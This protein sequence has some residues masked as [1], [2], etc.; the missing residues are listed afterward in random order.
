MRNLYKIVAIG[1][2]FLMASCAK[3]KGNYEFIPKEEITV[4]GIEASY[5][6]TA[7]SDPLVLKPEITSTDPNAKFEYMWGIYETAVQGYAPVLDT[8]AWT[9]D[10]DYEIVQSA[11]A[12]V[13]V[14]RV[15]NTNTGY[16]TYINSTLNVGTLYTRGW[17]VAKD[18]GSQSDLDLF[19]TPESIIPNGDKMENIYSQ[20]NGKKLDGKAKF[21]NLFSSYKSMVTG[22]LANTRVL[23]L[24]SE[25]DISVMN[26]N[27]L[28]NIRDFNTLFYGTPSVKA[29][30]NAFVGSSANYILN[31]GQLYSIYAMGANTGQ[32]GDRK[33]IND[34]NS[35]YHLSKYFMST[36]G[37][38]DPIFY[39]E[40]SSSFCSMSMG[41][42][43]SLTALSDGEGTELPT[44]NNN[45][46]LL[47]MGFK[48]AVYVPA[49]IYNYSTDGYAIVQDK[50]QPA[51]KSL[52]N[53]FRPAKSNNLEITSQIIE[54]SEKLYNAKLYT[55]LREDESLLYFTV[56]NELW[57]RNLSS[58]SEK[59]EYTVP[60]GEELTYIRHKAFSATGYSFN[61]VIVGSSVGGKY[62]IRMF[63]KASGSISGEPQFILEGDGNM[64]D[65]M[66]MAPTLYESTYGQSY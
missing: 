59:L 48:S 2:F 33:V 43:T 41:S 32:F 4:S 12:W 37:S 55:L 64:A 22:T 8:I 58:G 5:N 53:V 45:K 35:P 61:Y 11:K 10:L 26:V 14:Y 34:I 39:D 1:F 28:M 49:P 65:V 30:D 25:K 9:K 18:D 51:L 56:G 29:P 20:R 60:G 3:D 38:G 19:L 46:T 66:Y 36:G 6:V 23:A 54:P 31:N 13:L 17:Y 44:N 47:F 16:S 40:I 63:N 57:S 27:T 15:T 52:L 24:V 62:K 50:D 42:G 7:F 21:L